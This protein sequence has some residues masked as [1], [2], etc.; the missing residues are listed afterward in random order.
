M[1]SPNMSSIDMLDD[2]GL[3]HAVAEIIVQ[4]LGRQLYD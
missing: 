3:K 4:H 2:Q 1:R